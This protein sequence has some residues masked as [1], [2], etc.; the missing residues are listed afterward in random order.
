M[1]HLWLKICLV[2]F[3]WAVSACITTNTPPATGQVS[4]D[5]SSDTAKGSDDS[6]ASEV[7][8]QDDTAVSDASPVMDIE[9][10]NDIG[11][12]KDVPPCGADDTA[13]VTADAAIGAD[14]AIAEIQAQIDALKIDK[15]KPNWRSQLQKPTVVV[16]TP[17]RS[18]FW[19]FKTDKGD[20]KIKLRP[21]VAP[22][23]VT[24][25]IF[26]TQMGF[27]DNLTFHR[28]LK[29]FMAQ[30]G[31]PLGNGKGGP[32]YQYA[33]ETNQIASHDS[34]GVLSMANAGPNSEGSQ[35]FIT[36][37]PAKFL[38]GKYSVFGNMVEGDCTLTAIE[39]GGTVD[40]NSGSPVIVNILSAKITVE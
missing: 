24:S 11:T 4:A 35:F 18:Y 26:L 32:G 2:V 34:R 10:F 40:D 38:D 30:G 23:H 37:A 33:L 12:V 28:I 21:E 36:F 7:K 9:L 31:D 27:Y 5:A 1:K 19:Q 22:M 17:G 15:A 20:L 3:P 29:G 14:P 8:T 25:T 6:A 39:A 13:V 16:F